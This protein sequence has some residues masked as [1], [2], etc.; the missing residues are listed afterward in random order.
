MA[1]LSFSDKYTDA[2]WRLVPIPALIVAGAVN[3]AFRP[4]LI[5]AIASL[6][7]ALVGGLTEALIWHRL[8][9]RWIDL[10]PEAA[11]TLF[12]P[13]RQRDLVIASILLFVAILAKVFVVA[14]GVTTDA[15]LA[16]GIVIA[17]CAALVGAEIF[18]RRK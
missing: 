1:N 9:L 17:L 13:N 14:G 3:V 10:R 18:S 11:G 5:A 8:R 16:A 6:L 4:S 7:L 2:F 12:E 15:L